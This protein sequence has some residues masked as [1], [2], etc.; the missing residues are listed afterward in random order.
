[1][2]GFLADHVSWRWAFYINIPFGAAAI[3]LIGLGLRGTPSPRARPH[4]DLVGLMLFTT[5]VSSLLVGLLEGGRAAAWYAADVLGPLVAAL[6]LL[7]AFVLVERRAPEPIVPLMLFR[8]AIVRAAAANGFM[9]GMAMFGAIS[10]VP[11]FL[12]GVTHATATEAGFVL[13]P[14]ILGW[15]ICSIV[16]A[17]LALK[18]GYRILV[19]AG[20]TCL[21]LAFVL[22]SNW[23]ITLTRPSA[24]GAVLI[25][26]AGMGLTFVPLL[27]AVQN[28]VTRSD[29]G[30]ATSLTQFFR[31]IG[32]TVGV[33]V[34]GA[35]MTR[36]LETGHDIESSLQG[37]FLVGLV[38][39]VGALLSAF[40]VPAGSARE[41][42]RPDA[43][44]SMSAEGG[45][46]M[47]SAST[48][49]KGS[50]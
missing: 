8:N 22:F 10:F 33:S 14:F 17:R 49:A 7:V 29:L 11:L 30:S 26:G 45:P 23:D 24:M 47:V 48:P 41:L 32:G 36:R 44:A 12:Q 38:V 21:T 27:I 13:T 42:A 31:T 9:S 4:I 18:V 46:G 39:C 2:G 43:A 25:A 50:Q 20:M 6:A 37:V 40:L 16:G 5:G 3:A 28:A 35:V 1:M 19:I 34:M 15:V